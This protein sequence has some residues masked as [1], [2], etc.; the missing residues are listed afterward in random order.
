MLAIARIVAAAALA[1]T[2]ATPAAAVRTEYH[3]FGIVDTV[4]NPAGAGEVIAGRTFAEAIIRVDPELRTDVTAAAN[5]I[6]GTRYTRLEAAPIGPLDTL[7][8]E[9]VVLAVP[10]PIIIEFLRP[11]W[12]TTPDPLGIAG[13]YALFDDGRF[14]GLGFAAINGSG[15][16]VFLAGAAPQPFDFVGGDAL[17][18][19]PSFGGHFLPGSVPE[20]A[21]WAL[22]IAG[23]GATGTVLRRRRASVFTEAARN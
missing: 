16:A 9:F 18:E 21:S 13:P 20:P 14:F 12:I 1:A 17:L 2:L 7:N 22:M 15:T 23:F 5:A 10:P 8:F 6:Y 3:L 11:D 19:A 4:L